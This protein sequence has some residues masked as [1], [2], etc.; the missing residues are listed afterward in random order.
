MKQD[1]TIKDILEI[2]EFIRDNAATKE[3]LLQFATKEDLL[4]FATKEDLLQFATKEDLL[5]FA[6]KHELHSEIQTVKNELRSEI[7]EVKNEL[8][9]EIQEVKNELR[10]EIQEVKNEIMNHIDG[11]IGL[12]QKLEIELTALHGKYQC[13]ESYIQQIAKSIGLQLT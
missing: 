3:D 7:Q 6:T 9:S 13:L 10:S 1:N 8:R 5:Q 11:F 12:H 2:V 4:Q